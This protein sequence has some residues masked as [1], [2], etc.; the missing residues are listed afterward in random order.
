MKLRPCVLTLRFVDNQMFARP[1]EEFIPPSRFTWAGACV[2]EQSIYLTRSRYVFELE[3]TGCDGQ[4]RPGGDDF[5]C[6]NPETL[7]LV[8]VSVDQ[9]LYCRNG[10]TVFAVSEGSRLCSL[11]AKL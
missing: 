7:R 10:G 3:T 2:C 6:T 11:S 8:R 9:F 5:S 4:V 1:L